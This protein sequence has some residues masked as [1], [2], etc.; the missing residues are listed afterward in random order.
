[1]GTLWANPNTPVK[2]KFIIQQSR[3]NKAP[4]HKQIQMKTIKHLPLKAMVQMYY[5]YV[6]IEHNHFP[7]Q[8]RTSIIIPLRKSG[9]NSSLPDSYRPIS[10][11]S[12]LR[13][14]LEKLLNSALK[15]IIHEREILQSEQCGFRETHTTKYQLLRTIWQN[16]LIYKLDRVEIPIK[17]INIIQSF[18]SDRRFEVRIGGTTSD[19]RV[20]TA[21]VPLGSAL[22]PLLF[23]LLI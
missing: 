6:C 2:I 1:M 12:V 3:L 17:L 11:L 18:L 8:W 13:K 5:I 14:I 7:I 22:S 19:S 23:L 16:S 10:L 20:V 4:G 21:D 15:E 9:K